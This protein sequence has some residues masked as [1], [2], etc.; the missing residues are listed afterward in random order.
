M[1]QLVAR[2]RAK[3]LDARQVNRIPRIVV[4]TCQ[5]DGQAGRPRGRERLLDPLL[6]RDPSRDERSGAGHRVDLDVRHAVGQDSPDLDSLRA[7]VLPA[8]AR[9]GGQLRGRR[10]ADRRDDRGDDRRQVQRMQHGEP[11]SALECGGVEGVL[12]DGVDLEVAD[13]AEHPRDGGGDAR[14]RRRVRAAG[15][16]ESSGRVIR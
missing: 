14:R 3:V 10:R 15:H 1:A 4:R 9:D 12:A 8:C 11:T 6:G 13:V 16:H 2:E 5:A 7:P